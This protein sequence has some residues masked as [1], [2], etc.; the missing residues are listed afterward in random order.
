MGRERGCS[1]GW[2]GGT[3][4]PCAPQRRETPALKQ[5]LRAALPLSPRRLLVRLDPAP[6]GRCAP[7]RRDSPHLCAGRRGSGPLPAPG[8]GC[9][10]PRHPPATA[11]GAPQRAGT[12]GRWGGSSVPPPRGMLQELPPRAQAPC[13]AACSRCTPRLLGDAPLSAPRTAPPACPRHLAGDPPRPQPPPQHPPGPPGPAA[14]LHLQPPRR[15][16]PR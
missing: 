7:P 11:V 15:C 2:G 14:P 8:G 12:C 5:G 4:A 9:G 6:R 10:A 1:L 13:S 16:L 3:A